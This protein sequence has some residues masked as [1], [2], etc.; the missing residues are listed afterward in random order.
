MQFI[1]ELKEAMYG[2]NSS[3]YWLAERCARRLQ[4]RAIMLEKVTTQTS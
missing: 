3:K 4:L 2:R 1:S